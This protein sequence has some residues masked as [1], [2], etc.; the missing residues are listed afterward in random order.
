MWVF[1]FVALLVPPALSKAMH[2]AAT[3]PRLIS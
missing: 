2:G 1:L 3:L